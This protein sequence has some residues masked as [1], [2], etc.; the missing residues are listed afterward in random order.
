MEPYFLTAP[1]HPPLC[2]HGVL[3]AGLLRGERIGRAVVL[4]AAKDNP[5]TAT[6]RQLL[7]V[8]YGPARLLLSRR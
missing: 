6:L 8:T 7:V 2:Q 4:R 5:A 3:D 1:T